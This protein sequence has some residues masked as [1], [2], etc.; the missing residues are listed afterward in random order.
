MFQL[1]KRDQGVW[2]EITMLFLIKLINWMWSVYVHDSTQ[3][4]FEGI[5]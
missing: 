4:M 1:E 2:I 3:D 5:M